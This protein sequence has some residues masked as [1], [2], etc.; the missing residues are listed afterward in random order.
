MRVLGMWDWDE[1]MMVV[2]GAM[3]DY[4]EVERN[5]RRVSDVLSSA[6]RGGFTTPEGSDMTFSL[7]GRTC[8]PLIRKAKNPGKFTAC[9]DGEA[10]ISSLESSSTG[11]MVNPFSIEH[12]D[13]GFVSDPIRI[14]VKDGKAVSV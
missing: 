14:E 5:S 13:L 4:D 7:E 10:A 9:P 6:K 3:A 8:F 11:V 12:K 1:E 2:G